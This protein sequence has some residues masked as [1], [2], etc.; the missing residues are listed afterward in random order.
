M[1]FSPFYSIKQLQNKTDRIVN[2]AKQVGLFINVKKTEVMSIGVTA[3]DT[4][5]IEGNDIKNVDKFTYLG[6][7]ITNKDGA[8]ADIETRINKARTAF[9][10]LKNIWRSKRLSLKTKL[11]VYSSNVKTVWV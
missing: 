1:K 7:V 6:S 3:Q 4:I 8:K 10:S 11:K 9:K 2:F 5:K